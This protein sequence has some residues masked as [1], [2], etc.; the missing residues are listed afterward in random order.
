ML[1]S[2]P[3]ELQDL[4]RSACGSGDYAHHV[5]SALC[6]PGGFSAKLDFVR[7]EFLAAA[8]RFEASKVAQGAFLKFRFACAPVVWS[9]KIQVFV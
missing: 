1:A 2:D 6:L 5:C 4:V 8:L 7:S 9:R 3:A